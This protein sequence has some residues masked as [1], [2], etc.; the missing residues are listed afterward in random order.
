MNLEFFP[1]SRVKLPAHS[2]GLPGK[3]ISFI[4][5]P[6]TRLRGGACGPLAGHLDK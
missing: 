6:L 1:F 3:E 2:T 5:C 4:L